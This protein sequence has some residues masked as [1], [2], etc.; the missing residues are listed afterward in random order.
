MRTRTRGSPSWPRRLPT[1]PDTLTQTAEVRSRKPLA[2][3]AGHT[4]FIF[5]NGLAVLLM[6]A[7]AGRQFAEA[8]GAQLPAQRLFADRNG[9]S[10]EYPLRQIGQPP[11][12]HA[13]RRR[14]RAGLDDLRQGLALGG[15]EQ[16]DLAG[17]LAVDQ[18]RR[19]LGVERQHPVA[20]RLQADAADLGRLAARAAVVDRRQRQQSTGLRRIPRPFRQRPQLHRRDVL[21]KP[22]RRSHGKPPPR[23]PS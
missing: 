22:N 23:S 9:E 12:H 13:V 4:F 17:R 19:T 21:P 2:D 11:A 15:I 1:R 20:H 8:E 5:R 18:T 6:V 16:R 10:V 14:D 3:G 7:R